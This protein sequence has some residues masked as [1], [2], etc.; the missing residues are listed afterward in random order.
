MSGPN[1]ARDPRHS[2]INARGPRDHGP[3]PYTNSPSDTRRPGAQALV[4]DSMN[5]KRPADPRS[6]GNSPPDK[7]VRPPERSYS[8]QDRFAN[9]SEAA[10]RRIPNNLSRTREDLSSR[11]PSAGH[12]P[13][14]MMSP[15]SAGSGGSTPVHGAAPL[16]PSMLPRAVSSGTAPE[17]AVQTQ[18]GP[19]T[20]ATLQKLK[21]KKLAL[22]KSAAPPSHSKLASLVEAQQAEISQLK[23]DREDLF[24]KLKAV[25]SLPDRFKEHTERLDQIVTEAKDASILSRLDELEK[26]MSLPARIIELETA[27]KEPSAKPDAF[28]AELEKKLRAYV[29]ET[30]AAN[31]SEGTRTSQSE[32]KAVEARLD[33]HI[34]EQQDSLRTLSSRL[35]SVEELQVKDEER[36]TSIDR[37]L[38][39]LTRH[40]G[41]NY[42][43]IKS[44]KSRLLLHFGESKQEKP[45][46]G[47]LTRVEKLATQCGQVRTF[48]N[49]VSKDTKALVARVDKLEQKSKGPGAGFVE[50]G[51]PVAQP[52]SEDTIK[53]L[54]Q[55][56]K[57][58]EEIRPSIESVKSLDSKMDNMG[59]RINH[60]TASV[61]L[62]Q[63]E[64]AHNKEA[65]EG[66][67]NSLSSVSEAVHKLEA[68]QNQGTADIDLETRL[69][70]LEARIPS[71]PI[72]APVEATSSDMDVKIEYLYKA[73]GNLDDGLTAAEKTLHEH[74]HTIEFTQKEF[75]TLFKTNFDPFKLKAEQRLKQIDQELDSLKRQVQTQPPPT[76]GVDVADTANSLRQEF[77]SWLTNERGQRDHAIHEIRTELRQ[78][79]DSASTDQQMDTFRLSFRSLQD[80]YNNITTDEL[81]GRMVHWFLQN[82]PNS[83]AD[84]FQ[85]YSVVQHDVKRLQAL[86]NQVLW[87]QNHAQDLALVLQNAP[88]LQALVHPAGELARL[89]QTCARIE[90]VCFNA[91][92]ALAKAT[93]IGIT[94][95]ER[96]QQLD[97]VQ[98]A[99]HIL[100]QLP[101][102]SQAIHDIE[103]GFSELKANV[104][105]RLEA[106]RDAR[107]GAANELRSAASNEH[108][109]RVE[110]VQSLKQALDSYKLTFEDLN[111][112]VRGL[113]STTRN[114]RADVDH[115]ND[116]YITPNVDFF[117]LFGSVLIAIAELQKVA[118]DLNQN[119]PKGPLNITWNSVIPDGS[120]ASNDKQRKDA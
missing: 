26:L 70:S 35:Q 30:I 75:P 106:E 85:Q 96:G 104:E 68:T 94:L 3:S 47:L 60:V 28:K 6:R 43:D 8:A 91:D 102:K 11:R 17:A 112:R 62:V 12:S 57:D 23:K 64:T 31:F 58:I 67:K 116:N 114:L 72:Q 36:F 89:Q 7:R 119:L 118:E 71:T 34:K 115:I 44:I 54:D 56:D 27:A 66:V 39:K 92:S 55:I 113:D 24:E 20:L 45:G 2:N 107:I 82:F 98:A 84:L 86:S 109:R 79:A 81:H 80:Q 19:M 46:H 50:V 117:G 88:Q 29:L 38:K 99:V 37:D 18:G 42:D 110:E 69:T 53:R 15:G 52:L 48:H 76:P 33:Q 41:D 1:R 108:D 63:T 32:V 9:S 40:D 59:D 25:E 74:T 10:D 100:Q 78:K 90:D 61:Q 14:Q 21:T 51:T 95:M 101:H 5:R 16:V 73:V 111:S 65:L 22:T 105:A 103:R 87:I 83:T 120:G 97:A 49:D 13:L 77:Q 4:S 93:E